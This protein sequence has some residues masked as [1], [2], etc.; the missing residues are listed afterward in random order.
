MK[1]N[2][3]VT[4]EPSVET[5]AGQERVAGCAAHPLGDKVSDNC[6]LKPFRP[7]AVTL[8]SAVMGVVGAIWFG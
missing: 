2:V 3:P 8:M 5:L 6:W 7:A 4:E 1:E